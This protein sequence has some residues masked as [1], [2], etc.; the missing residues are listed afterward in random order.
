MTKMC[1][2]IQMGGGYNKVDICKTDKIYVRVIYHGDKKLFTRTTRYD[3]DGFVSSM[4]D[5]YAD[6]TTE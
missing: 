5:V 6:G 2:K 1:E 3:A 4:V